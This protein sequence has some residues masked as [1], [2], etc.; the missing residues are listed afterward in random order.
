MNRVMQAGAEDV[1][2]YYRRNTRRFLRRGGGGRMLA[3]HRQLWL[4]GVSSRQ[5]AFAAVNGLILDRLGSCGLLPPVSGEDGP[6]AGGKPRIIDLGC[7]AGGTVLWLAERSPLH[8]VGV[9][10][11]DQQ[12]RMARR[13]ARLRRL[14]A[15][16]FIHADFHH[17]PH[18]NLFHAAS[19]VESFSHSPDPGLFFISAARLLKKGG[20]LIL[21][22]DFIA[23]GS[24][25]GPGREPG[26]HDRNLSKSPRGVPRTRRNRRRARQWLERFRG[27]WRLHSLLSVEKIERLAGAAGFELI[28]NT[29]LT[30]YTR[31]R[32][33]KTVPL[34]PLA[35]INN[36]S[37]FLGN[38]AGG[39]SLRYCILSGFTRYR[40]LVF[41]LLRSPAAG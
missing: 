24:G 15:C 3:M 29:D 27:G 37:P 17:L 18:T 14:A 25:T 23:S 30:G 38:I 8:A 41:R 10:N 19:A 6:H 1:R 32:W 7:G 31:T 28:E 34:L 39:V 40:L 4:P 11:N 22:D 36:R 26:A 12:V 20:L 35:L 21:A 16:E 9:T 2:E 13:A 5:E 33:W